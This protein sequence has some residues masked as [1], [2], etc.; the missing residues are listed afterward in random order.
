MKIC[1]AIG[2]AISLGFFTQYAQAQGADCSAVLKQ[3]VFQTSRYRDNSYFQQIIYSRFLQSTYQSSKEDR[4]AGFGVP[5]GEIVL[6]G[7][8]SE[9]DYKARKQQIEREYFSQIT[10]NRDVDVA[11]A[12]GDPEVLGAWKECIR[13]KGG[14][15]TVRFDAST[16]TDIIGYIEW[17]S[18]GIS[19]TTRLTESAILPTGF[20]LAAGASCLKKGKVLHSGNPCQFRIIADN[21]KKSLPFTINSTR[22]GASAFL[23]ARIVRV[24]DVKIYPTTAEDT[25]NTYA[26]RQTL[27]PT[28]TLS[29]TEQDIKDGWLFDASTARARLYVIY[30][31]GMNGCNNE[32]RGAGAYSY[33]YGFTIWGHTRGN[34]RNW[35]FQC[36]L[37]IGIMM[38]RDRWVGQG[39]EASGA[40]SK[41]TLRGFEPIVA[42]ENELNMR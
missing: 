27:T 18:E 21:P 24:R 7:S 29:L 2:I 35:G 16:G 37:D 15:L 32:W 5:V 36:A 3:G 28:R 26:F 33:S 25:L 30:G 42:L 6:G 4:D 39:I 19:A 22:K 14:G 13:Q 8:Y 20:R 40:E 1:N 17:M 12:S 9:S 31:G 23:P 41:A 34:D 11:L 10:R 38:V